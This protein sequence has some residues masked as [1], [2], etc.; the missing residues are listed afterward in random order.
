MEVEG[1]FGTDGEP[2][3]NVSYRAKVTAQASEAEIR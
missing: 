1:E 3:K 2:A